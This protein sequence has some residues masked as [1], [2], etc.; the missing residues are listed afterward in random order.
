[1]PPVAELHHA[2]RGRFKLRLDAKRA[3]PRQT[4]LSARIW[5]AS[6]VTQNEKAE[7]VFEAMQ[8]FG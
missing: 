4:T 8:A 7:L 6:G 3:G 2:H 1:M 5:L